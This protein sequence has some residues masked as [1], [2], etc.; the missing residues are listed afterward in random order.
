MSRYTQ[1][2][3]S[4]IENECR[5][6]HELLEGDPE[7]WEHVLPKALSSILLDCPLPSNWQPKVEHVAELREWIG[8]MCLASY[9]AFRGDFGWTIDRRLVACDQ[10]VITR[11]IVRKLSEEETQ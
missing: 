4:W 6:A 11:S 2:E 1:S 3:L 10:W 5:E 7:N 9:R 8:R